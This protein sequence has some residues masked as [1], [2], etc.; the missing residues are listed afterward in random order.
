MLLKKWDF[1]YSQDINLLRLGKPRPLGV[2]SLHV[3]I[4]FFSKGYSSVGKVT[5]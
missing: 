1:L 3:Q 4:I 5:Q 2:G